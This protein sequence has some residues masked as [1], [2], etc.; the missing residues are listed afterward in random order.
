M[1][2]VIA[3]LVGVIGTMQALESIHVLLGNG[4]LHGALWLFDAQYMEWQKMT[5]PKNPNCPA[6]GSKAS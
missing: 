2:G 4:Q 5:L 3:P 1:E 6:C